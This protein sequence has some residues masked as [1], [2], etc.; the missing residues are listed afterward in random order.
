MKSSDLYKR[1][2][3]NYKLPCWVY[4]HQ[5]TIFIFTSSSNSVIISFRIISFCI[6]FPYWL[7]SIF[8]LHLL[9]LY[10]NINYHLFTSNFIKWCSQCSN[11]VNRFEINYFAFQTSTASLNGLLIAYSFWNRSNCSF[12]K[13]RLVFLSFRFE[14][15]GFMRFDAKFVRWSC[16]DEMWNEQKRRRK[17]ISY[18]WKK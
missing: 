5:C 12:T 7:I 6:I 8:L 3:S 11:F 2:G 13:F 1:L 9:F 4:I 18:N 15:C 14:W 17:L 10:I 16:T